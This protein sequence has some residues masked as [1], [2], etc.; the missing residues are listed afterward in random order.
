MMANY[1]SNKSLHP[2]GAF[3]YGVLSLQ[4]KKK[5]KKGESLDKH[6]G[7]CQELQNGLG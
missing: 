6:P 5:K 2:L 4:Q 3:G 7:Q 1:K